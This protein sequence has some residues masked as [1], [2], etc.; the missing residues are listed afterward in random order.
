MDRSGLSELVAWQLVNAS[1]VGGKLAITVTAAD[2]EE[3]C[4]PTEDE[5]CQSVELRAGGIGAL[6]LASGVAG[7][8]RPRRRDG[9]PWE[10]GSY[11]RRSRRR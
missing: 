9:Q 5:D 6:G 4:Y 10:T 8:E 2:F 11:P 3:H 7:D 1:F